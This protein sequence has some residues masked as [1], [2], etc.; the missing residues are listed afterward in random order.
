M[1]DKEFLLKLGANIKRIRLEKKL[2]QVE[3]GNLCDFE[4]SAMNRIEAGRTNL[5]I[6]NLKKIA[7]GLDV[8]LLDVINF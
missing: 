5:T 2:T 3:L 1:E 4:K 6:L 7:N 8:T